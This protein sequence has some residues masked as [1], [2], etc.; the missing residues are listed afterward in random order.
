MKTLDVLA[1]PFLFATALV[2]VLLAR[3]RSP[4]LA[5]SGGT[6]LALGLVGLAVVEGLETW[7]STWLVTHGPT[8]AP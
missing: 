2:Y 6:L 3:G 7:V 4:R 8:R 1:L 5:W